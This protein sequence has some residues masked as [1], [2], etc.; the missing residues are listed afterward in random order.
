MSDLVLAFLRKGEV[1]KAWE[2]WKSSRMSN[3]EI[4]RAFLEVGEA[5]KT[6]AVI[7]SIDHEHWCDELIKLYN[8]AQYWLEAELLG[9]VLFPEYIPFEER[10]SAHLGD[11]NPT[12]WYP[13]RVVAMD[14]DVVEIEYGEHPCEGAQPRI[15]IL[16]LTIQEFRRISHQSK[17]DPIPVERFVEIHVDGFGNRRIWFHEISP[18]E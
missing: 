18:G 2:S 12:L 17:Y 4:A 3:L 1:K 15:F 6:V 11:T 8:T 5:E 10:W 9:T 14:A 13:G 7:E 16:P